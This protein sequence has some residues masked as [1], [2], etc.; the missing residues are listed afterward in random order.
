[1]RARCLQSAKCNQSSR[2]KLKGDEPL[3][4][5]AF[6]LAMRRYTTGLSTEQFAGAI[7]DMTQPEVGLCRLTVSKPEMKARLVSAPGTEM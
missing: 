2:L 7:C 5:V 4:N 1:M 6:N 3:S